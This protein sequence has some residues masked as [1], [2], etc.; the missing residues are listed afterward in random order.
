[1]AE[2][3]IKITVGADTSQFQ[4]ELTKAENELKQ[5]QSALRKS[6]DVNEIKGLQTQITAT[7]RTI[8]SLKTSIA[9]ASPQFQRLSQSTNTAQ[10]AITNLNRVVSDSPYGFIGIANNIN[11]LVESFGRLKAESG[12][13]SGA[14]KAMIS[15]LT[16]PAGI[17]LAISALTAV[18]TFAQIGFDRWSASSKKAKEQADEFKK[19]QEDFTKS[20]ESAQSSALATAMSLQQYIDIAK[21]GQ[22]PLNQRNEAL[23]QANKILGVHG[24]KLTLVNIGTAKTTEQVNLFTQA[25]LQQAIAAKYTDRIAELTIKQTRLTKERAEAEKDYNKL[26][27]TG[28][29]TEN[30]AFGL[31]LFATSGLIAFHKDLTKKVGDNVDKFNNFISVQNEYINT[32]YEI[33]KLQG[34]LNDAT[35]IATES[36]GKLGYKAKESGKKTIESIEQIIAKMK[37]DLKD[38]INVGIALN[39]PSLKERIGILLE[40]VKKLVS[41]KNVAPDAEILIPIKQELNEL[42]FVQKAQENFNKVDLAVKKFN[43]QIKVPILPVVDQK[44]IDE[45]SSKIFNSFLTDAQISQL[46]DSITQTAQD[47]AITFS[48]TLGQALKGEATFTDF[49]KGMFEVIGKGMQTFG[50][51]MIQFA[52]K[53]EAIKKW[54]IANPALA[55]AGGIALIALGALLASQTSKKSA[56][57]VG[58]NYAPGGMALV[59]ERGPELI[60]LPRGS[61]VVPAAQTSNIMK[62]A[63]QQVEVYGV[64]RG[65]DIFFSNKKYS[66]TYNRTT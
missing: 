32:G 24:E 48:T 43:P 22:L 5:F 20:L 1:M 34:E 11:P 66:Q 12:S 56:F 53:V 19:S 45:Q 38:A 18:I 30:E 9:S 17:G 36:F 7:E 60:N 15:S 42:E 37:E 2:E 8:S 52:I 61:Q 55:I 14:L 54:A 29:A 40:T 58:T 63:A 35:E 51:Y 16:G 41:E 25:L 44:P 13:T 4:A 31:S 59:G 57:A 26:K 64:L 62:G 65:Q 46:N 33:A 21:N 27:E 6:M 3:Q 49:F 28:I 39:E 10:F 47:L 23:D 50:K